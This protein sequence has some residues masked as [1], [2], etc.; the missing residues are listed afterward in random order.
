MICDCGS[1][2]TY[3]ILILRIRPFDFCV[4]RWEGAG[5]IFK[6]NFKDPL[7]LGK[8]ARTR[9]NAIV[10][11]VKKWIKRQARIAGDGKFQARK[12][13]TPLP[14]PLS[15]TLPRKNQ[16]MVD[17]KVKLD[18]E[19]TRMCSVIPRKRKT[20]TKLKVLDASRLPTCYSS[21]IDKWIPC[22][23]KMKLFTTHVWISLPG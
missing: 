11:F 21:N 4:G 23:Y 6:K 13:L 3:S 19:N 7:L 12:S 16:Q 20:K 15:T 10:R 18:F 2:W 17:P 8:I 5:R 14:L 1:S 9:V 22:H